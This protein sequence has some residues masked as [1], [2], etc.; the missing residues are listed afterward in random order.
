MPQVKS[1]NVIIDQGDSI[2]LT[3]TFQSNCKLEAMWT[4]N[5][6]NANGLRPVKEKILENNTKSLMYILIDA[7]KHF[8]GRYSCFLPTLFSSVNLNLEVKGI[9][10]KNSQT[11]VVY[12]NHV[13]T[14]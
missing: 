1:R 6:E 12:T 9:T 13:F 8:G 14:V 2:N 3:C 5:I 10:N 4:K 11:D 7:E